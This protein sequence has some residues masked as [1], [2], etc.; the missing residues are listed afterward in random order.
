[1]GAR[2]SRRHRITRR[3]WVTGLWAGTYAMAVAT[4][5]AVIA[6]ASR[7]PN[8]VALAVFAALIVTA[9]SVA[10]AMLPTA[11]VSPRFM[12]VMASIVA[13]VLPG[14]MGDTGARAGQVWSDMA[15]ALPN[16]L[17]FGLLGTLAGAMYGQLGPV[18]VVL[19]LAPVG[20]AR[21]TF[22]SYLELREAQEATVRVL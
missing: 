16:Y 3:R 17:A 19:L 1:M 8:L 2:H 21:R 9:E 10:A 12:L 5:I 6:G 22:A 20:I 7:P 4:L 15:P 14:I 18:A 11:R 13:F